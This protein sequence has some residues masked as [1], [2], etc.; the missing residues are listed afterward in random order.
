MKQGRSL[1]TH[2]SD[3]NNKKSMY[4]AFYDVLKNKCLGVSRR[5]TSGVRMRLQHGR[6]ILASEFLLRGSQTQVGEPEI[7]EH[8]Q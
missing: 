4:I 3:N 6:Q 5:S 1:Y 2:Q 7:G 8:G